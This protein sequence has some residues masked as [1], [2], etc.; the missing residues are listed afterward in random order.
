VAGEEGKTYTQAEVDALIAEQ[1]AGLKANRDELLKESKKAREA[2]KNYEGVDPEEHRR[3]KDAAAEAE[4]KKAAAEGDFKSLEAQ[5][6]KKMADAEAKFAAEQTRLRGSLDKYLIDAEAVRE[7]AAHSDSPALLL[8]HIRGQMRVIEQDGAF[9]AR[10][11]DAAG[12]V[13]IG[14]G[15]GSAPM[16]LGE[17]IEDMKQDRTYAPAFRGTGS[18][19]GGASKTTAGGGLASVVAAG[20][21]RAFLANLDG[22]AKGTVEVR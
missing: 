4:R 12:N 2:L 22:I 14:K 19:G 16:T 8:P 15:Q 20:D 10:I 17:L 1:T 9:V 7:L 18:S 3:L 5:L 21:D 6:V 11:V 13:R